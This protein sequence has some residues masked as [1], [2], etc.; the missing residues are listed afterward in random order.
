LIILNEFSNP[1]ID[2]VILALIH[3]ILEDTMVNPQ[4]IEMLF[5]KKILDKLIILSKRVARDES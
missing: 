2:K 1:T 5:S 4:T 3:D